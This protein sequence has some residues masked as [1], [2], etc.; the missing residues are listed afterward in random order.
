AAAAELNFHPNAIARSLTTHR[1]HVLGMVIPYTQEEFFLDPFFPQ[2]LRGLSDVACRQGF[3][4]LLSGV[5][6]PTEEPEAV[7][8]LIRSRQVDGIVVQAS[9]VGVDTTD[10]LLAERHPFVLLGRPLQD[11]AELSWVEVDAHQ[12]TLEA[13]RHLIGLGHRRIAFIAGYPNMVVTLDRLAGYRQALDE[14][15]LPY[16]E[17]LVAYGQFRQE[18]GAEAMRPFLA[19]NGSRPTAVFAANDLMAVG[20][21][22]AAAEAG[23]EVPRDCSVVGSNDSPVAAFSCPRLTS[24]RAPYHELA[25][26]AAQALIAQLQ[27]MPPDPVK[28]LLPC[29]LVVRESTAPPRAGVGLAG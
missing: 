9:R 24:S 29:E 16:D 7:L 26:E 23:L 4:L 12:A 28:R 17:G 2:V 20:A 19:M 21:M 22:Q 6:D 13:V 1:A 14:A 25:R 27:G 10:V 8:R 15:G 3:R 5:E 11:A 18:G